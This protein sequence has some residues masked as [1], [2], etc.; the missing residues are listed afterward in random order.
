MKLKRLLRLLR[1]RAQ[2]RYWRA[3]ALKAEM[4]LEAERYRN[5]TRED[6]FVSASVM[7][8][9]GMFGVPP[10]TGPA[11]K[12]TITTQIQQQPLA[13]TGAERLEFE[14]LWLPDARVA[15]VDDNTALRDFMQ[16]IAKR[17]VPLN[18]EPYAH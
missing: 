15:G 12:K 4:R 9:R 11:A 6:F 10:R 2:V 7:G 8:Q 3:R 17:R 16:E 13:M 18:D 5:L 14:T 1:L